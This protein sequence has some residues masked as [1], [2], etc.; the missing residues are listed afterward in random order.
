MVNNS[1]NINKMS[2]H[3]SIQ[4]IEHTHKKIKPTYGIGNSGQTLKCGGGSSPSFQPSVY[5]RQDIADK[6]AHFEQE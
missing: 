6:F 4:A 2:N 3:L 1:T 5:F